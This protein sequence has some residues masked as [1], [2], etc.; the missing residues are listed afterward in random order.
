MIHSRFPLRGKIGPLLITLVWPASWLQIQPVAEYHFFPLWLGYILTLDA[1]V[2]IRRGTS[3]F[4]RSRRTFVFLFVISAP[5]WWLFELF[6]RFVVNW[7]Y[8]GFESTNPIRYVLFASLAFSTVVPAVFETTE[9]FASFDW[10]QRI[11][12]GPIIRPTTLVL[13]GSV[14]FGILSF[15]AMILFP[16]YTFP[17]A[18]TCVFFI[19]DPINYVLGW[20]SITG[21]VSTGE[22]RPVLAIWAGTLM[23]GFFWELWNYYAYPKWIYEIPF[24]EFAHIFEMPLLGY[25]GYLTFG[26]E[27]FAM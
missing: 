13:S 4:T 5:V 18:W 12:H 7:I 16:R 27:I 21:W 2:F 10:I 9:L 11:R 15:G 25:G 14:I 24:V 26:L 17:F 1:I 3:L 22:W 23:C 8:I 20:S 19:L 6:N